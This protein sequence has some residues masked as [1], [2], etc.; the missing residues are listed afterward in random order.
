MHSDTYGYALTNWNYDLAFFVLLC[1]LMRNVIE[2]VFAERFA[3]QQ[4]N[5]YELR[6]SDKNK[7]Y[8]RINLSIY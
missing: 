6:L 4:D 2:M 1:S 7:V 8:V 3:Y 5:D